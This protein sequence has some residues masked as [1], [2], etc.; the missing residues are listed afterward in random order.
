MS[1]SPV[2]IKASPIAA[3]ITNF[4]HGPFLAE[5]VAS[6]FAQTL[7]VDRVILVDDA[8]GP[9]RNVSSARWIR[10]LRSCDSAKTPAR[11]VPDR[12]VPTFQAATWLPTS[13]RT[14]CGCPPRS[15]DSTRT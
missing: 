6:V 12:Q 8:S 15:S 14:I 7:P 10:E 3:I 9:R 2:A 13:T 11:A 4:R 5:A 1:A